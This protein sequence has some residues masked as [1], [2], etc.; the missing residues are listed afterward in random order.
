MQVNSRRRRKRS[1]I[2]GFSVSTDVRTS[3]AS[4]HVRQVSNFLG[5]LAYGP[6]RERETVRIKKVWPLLT[7]HEYFSHFGGSSIR[8]P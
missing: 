6:V 8:L 5:G 1:A 4:A 2:K 7:Y 3:V